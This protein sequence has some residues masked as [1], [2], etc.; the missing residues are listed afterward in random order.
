[1]TTLALRTATLP[2]YDRWLVGFA[3]LALIAALALPWFAE[4]SGSALTLALGSAA[5]AH[6]PVL[7][8]ALLSLWFA[9]RSNFNALAASAAFALAWVVL[10]DRALPAADVFFGC[11]M[12][13]KYT[14][15]G[16]LRPIVSRLLAAE[17]AGTPVPAA[18]TPAVPVRLPAAKT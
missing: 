1:M 14:M 9:W 6:A 12:V 16:I 8:A 15:P 18:A 17:A 11:V 3:A 7:A 13:A 2:R 10:G 4:R 5:T